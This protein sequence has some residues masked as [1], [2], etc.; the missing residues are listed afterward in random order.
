MAYSS[1]QHT[2]EEKGKS[3]AGD[4]T[5]SVWEDV[6]TKSVVER[7]EELHTDSLCASGG[8]RSFCGTSVGDRKPVSPSSSMLSVWG[9]DRHRLLPH[10]VPSPTVVR[11]DLPSPLCS[12][13]EGP[14]G[15][16]LGSQV[17]SLLPVH[18]S[19]VFLNLRLHLCC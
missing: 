17:S 11:S 7:R 8:A 15:L 6:Y 14:A 13:W 3:K 16:R 4:R 1:G 10:H 2:Y 5:H 19:G 18:L 12:S 9:R